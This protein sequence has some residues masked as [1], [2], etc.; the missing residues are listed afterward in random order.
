ML[1]KTLRLENFRKFKEIELT[2]L[3]GINEIAATNKWGKTT[4]ADALAWILTDK[5]YSGSSD[6]TSI[7][8]A[9]DSTQ[10]VLVEV[11]IEYQD[12]ISKD[13]L[14]VT[15]KKEY[16][17]NWVKTRG[18]TIVTL[19]G[20]TTTYYINNIKKLAGDF[21][22]ELKDIF[23]VKTLEYVQIIINPVYF[24]QVMTWQKRREIVNDIIGTIKPEEVFAAD[25]TLAVLKTELAKV[26]NDPAEAK[27]N[28]SSRMNG[29][30]GLKQ[31]QSDLEAVINGYAS[32]LAEPITLEASKAAAAALEDNRSAEV[33]LKVKKESKV[34]P[35]LQKLKEEHGTKTTEL[36]ES[37]RSDNAML[38]EMNSGV[39][40]DIRIEN[41]TLE[42]LRQRRRELL[43]DLARE[44]HSEE[45][46]TQ[47]QNTYNRVI[48]SKRAKLVELDHE[49]DEVAA[50]TFQ[51]QT[52]AVV[53]PHCNEAFDHE[54]NADEEKEFSTD[55]MKQIEAINDKGA[56]IKQEIA[57][58][59]QTIED[60]KM[61]EAAA[62]IEVDKINATITGLD[63]KIDEQLTKVSDA[64]NRRRDFYESDVTITLKK[65]IEEIKASIR[66]EQNVDTTDEAYDKEM[67]RIYESNQTQKKVLAKFDAETIIRK[68]KEAAE[69]KLK[70]VEQDVADTETII[71]QIKL[72]IKTKLDIMNK[73]LENYFGNVKFQLIKENIKA[74]SYDEVCFVLDETPDG[75]VPYETTNTESKIRIGIQ[76]IEGIKANLGIQNLPIIIDNCEA[77]TPSNR[78]FETRAQLV[79]MIAAD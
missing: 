34:N 55:Q 72:Y 36:N 58:T 31:Q 20:H 41:E 17:E 4:I 53:C 43:S 35:K 46:A 26:G 63:K 75:L 56:G 74:D 18:T 3:E 25:P 28:V 32:S 67:A 49:F 8:N 62:K 1:L 19:S 29:P 47:D 7:K 66:T 44:K 60:L 79:C 40:E 23:R 14:E 27:K 73:R 78:H 50:K 59:Q 45:K 38:T 6:T 2:F 15:L 21:E 52:I 16:Q 12:P 39:L 11:T 48:A 64:R 24:S 5:L 77:V 30:K 37:V 57:D 13:Y 68:N 70:E 33:N 22:K 42:D 76:I 71:D 65:Q 54:L 51:V 61:S 9:T 69:K 10:K